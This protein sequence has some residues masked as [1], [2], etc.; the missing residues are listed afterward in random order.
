MVEDY[1]NID[2]EPLISFINDNGVD[3]FYTIRELVAGKEMCSDEEY[4]QRIETCRSCSS[5]AGPEICTENSQLVRVYCR[6]ADSVCPL[7]KW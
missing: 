5:F 7:K 3:A 6:I 4:S 1:M 2:D